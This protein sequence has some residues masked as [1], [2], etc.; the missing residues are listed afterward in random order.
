VSHR[1]RLAHTYTGAHAV[2]YRIAFLLKDGKQA[3]KYVYKENVS[4]EKKCQQPVDIA[5][6]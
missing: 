1:N 3:K 2:W 6:L 5:Q 4:S